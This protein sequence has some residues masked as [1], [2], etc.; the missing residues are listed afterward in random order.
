MTIAEPPRA[1]CTATTAVADAKAAAP[2]PTGLPKV[3]EG[4]VKH[5]VVFVL[6]GPGS[7]KG[8]Q[9][10]RLVQEFGVVHLSAGDLL[11]EHMKSGSPEGQMVAD[12]IKNGQI[13]PSHVTISLLQK[14]MDDSGKHKFLI[15]GFP[16]NEENRAS[17]ES[18]TG[19]MP[20]LVL[21]FDC[22]EEVMERRLLGR[23]EGRTDDNIETIRKRFK[24]FI[25][26]SLPVIQHYEA[27]GKVARIN[28]DRDTEE[29][30]KEVRR[31]FME[32]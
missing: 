5:K 14:A 4:A 31:L 25:D 22:P 23:N 32:L 9:S 30:Y 24:V 8:T 1:G 29:I 18:Q 21:F 15:D 10:A 3:A 26:S 16:R 28:A 11:R 12:M 13:V 20:D 7:G 2:L 6:G 19:I 17:F 27:L